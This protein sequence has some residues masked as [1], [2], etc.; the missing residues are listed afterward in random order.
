MI[1]TLNLAEACHL[2]GIHLTLYATGCIFEYDEEHP[3]GGSTFTEEDTPNFLGSFYRK[4]KAYVE[5]MMKSYKNVS[6]EC[7]C[8]S[9][10]TSIPVTLL[11]KSSATTG[12]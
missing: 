5:D 7:A 12:W 4:T 1:G 2:K 11:R 8:P 3:I 10:M 6:F 9:P